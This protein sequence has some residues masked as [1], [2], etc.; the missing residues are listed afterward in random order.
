VVFAAATIMLAV[1]QWARA[2]AM[3]WGSAERPLVL[4]RHTRTAWGTALAV[5]TIVTLVIFNSLA[6][7]II[8]KT[9]Q[10]CTKAY[11]PQ[12]AAHMLK[13]YLMAA[14]AAAAAACLGVLI[15]AGDDDGSD[16]D[17]A[18]HLQA[19][20][21]SVMPAPAVTTPRPVLV[22]QHLADIPPAP[23]SPPQ[24]QC[25]SR[26][27]GIFYGVNGHLQ[28]GLGA[29]GTGGDPIKSYARQVSQLNDLGATMYAQDVYS[30]V[31]AED[32]AKFVRFAKPYC[33]NVLAVLTPDV[34]KNVDEDAA[35]KEGL[36]L[37]E[38]V[39]KPLAG[40]VQYYE[41]GNEFENGAI[42]RG[43]AGDEPSNYDNARFV[44]ARGSI[45]GMI[46]GIKR[47]DPAAKIVLCAL[48]WLHYGFSDMLFAGTQPDGSGGHPI[49]QWDITAWHWYSN[50]HD[51]T[52]V[53]KHFTIG[54]DIDVLQHLRDVYRKP[55]W[56]TEFGAR[57]D[58]NEEEAAAYL[59]G[60]NALAGYVENADKYNIQ[61]VVI[62]ELYDDYAY[63]GDGNYG[64]FSSNGVTKKP[65][66]D[67]VKNFIRANPMP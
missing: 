49:P 40:L 54:K 38:D 1:L 51:I 14:T 24:I 43:A 55:I 35:Y 64:L 32:L 12:V 44:K 6:P 60:P 36:R 25:G 65:R 47:V 9:F 13:R 3:A 15:F 53:T 21:P 20:R 63:G 8:C 62:Y 33:I 10:A 56:I 23:P 57:P 17:I 50:M 5:I 39:A 46:D 67:A 7:D 11:Q 19:D 58:L 66:Y 4:S 28:Q 52:S 34:Q 27:A 16:H 2:V 26:T 45:L 29:Y 59:V 22:A 37:G 41:V 30:K 42:L 31:G 61:G 48:G 18:V